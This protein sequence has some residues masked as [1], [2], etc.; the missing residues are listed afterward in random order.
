ML[1]VLHAFNYVPNKYSF[2]LLAPRLRYSIHEPPADL[3]HDTNYPYPIRILE[4]FK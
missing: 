2:C 3:P 4:V 1:R